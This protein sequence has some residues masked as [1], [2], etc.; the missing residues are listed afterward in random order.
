MSSAVEYT[1]ADRVRNLDA[2]RLRRVE[3]VDRSADVHR[4]AVRRIGL[5][6][7]QQQSRQVDHVRDAALV[8]QARERLSV[9]DVALHELDLGVG[10]QAEAAVVRPEVEADD[11]DTL[12]GEQRTGPGADA[13]ERAG[14]QEAL[15]A[16]HG[17]T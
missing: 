1:A 3:D 13:A 16:A 11:L 6:L 17:S 14:D 9:D 4:G 10:R 15:G 5:D 12:L 7:R 2:A 8:E